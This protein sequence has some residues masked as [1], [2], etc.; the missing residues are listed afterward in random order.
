MSE[1]EE[2][3]PCNTPQIGDLLRWDEPIWTKPNKPR[4]KPDKIGEQQIT[5]QLIATGEVLEL[6]VLSLKK[7][8][9]GDA[10]LKVQEGD[11]IR[12]KKT[13]LDKGA[14]HKRLP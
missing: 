2:W 6:K 5:A 12:R 4:G 9:Q 1:K 10:P 7:L 13:S 11:N 8:S 14:C 3:I